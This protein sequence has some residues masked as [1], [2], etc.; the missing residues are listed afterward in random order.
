MDP[1]N[2]PSTSTDVS[3]IE[4]DI[5]HLINEH[6][7][8]L[9]LTPLAFYAPIQSTSRQHSNNMATGS[10]PFGHAGFSER[11]NRLVNTLQGSAAA[12]NVAIGQRSAQEVVQSWLNSAQHRQNIEGDFNLTGISAVRDSNGDW[13][14]TQLFIKAPSPSTSALATATGSA[15]QQLNYQIH[16]RINQHRIQQYLPALQINPHVQVVALQHAQDMAVGNLGFGHQG[17]EDR[18]R[19]LLGKLG[20]KSAAENVALA[21]ADAAQIVQN[22]LESSGHRNNIEG[23]FNLTGI[24]IAK[25]DDGRVYCCQLFIER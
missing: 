2:T 21:P 14:F 25:G 20:G 16:D 17:F 3:A 6:R 5:L 11:A 4:V 1:S 13:V 15:E 12:E 24:G 9:K 22:W 18:A 10:V 7:A 23:N 19:S 8:G